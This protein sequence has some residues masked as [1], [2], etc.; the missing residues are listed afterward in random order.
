MD[1]QHMD[2]WTSDGWMDEWT[3]EWVYF[4]IE[5]NLLPKFDFLFS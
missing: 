3:D 1:G 2:G 5:V 4:L